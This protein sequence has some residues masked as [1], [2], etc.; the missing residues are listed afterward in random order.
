MHVYPLICNLSSGCIQVSDIPI[1]SGLYSAMYWSRLGIFPLR[2][3]ALVQVIVTSSFLCF[4][5]FRY[6]FFFLFSF[7][8]VA[9]A[10]VVTTRPCMIGHV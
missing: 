8:S 6:F 9:V 10:G 7:V 1:M 3:L 2:P 4:L 5:A